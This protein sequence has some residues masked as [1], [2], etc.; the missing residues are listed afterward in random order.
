MHAVYNRQ[1]YGVHPYFPTVFFGVLF[2][3]MLFVSGKGYTRTVWH[4]CIQN[5]GRGFTDGKYGS[6]V[7]YP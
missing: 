5:G 1:V 3:L 4:L 7:R 2:T 6:P